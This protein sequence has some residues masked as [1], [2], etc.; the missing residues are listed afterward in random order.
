[1]ARRL[2]LRLHGG[3]QRRQLAALALA[4]GVDGLEPEGAIAGLQHQRFTILFL[5]AAT[6]LMAITAVLLRIIPL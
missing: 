5:F 3:Q 4:I 1:M 6:L 2:A